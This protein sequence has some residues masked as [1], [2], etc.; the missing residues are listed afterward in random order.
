MRQESAGEADL[1]LGQGTWR[2]IEFQATVALAAMLTPL[3]STMLAVGLPSIRS[4]FDVGVGEMTLLISVYLVAVAAMQPVSGRL[5]DAYGSIRMMMVGLV[6]L[7]AISAVSALATN[8]PMLILMRGLQGAATALVL[9]NGIAV[10]RK[11]TP[12]ARL[13][14]VLGMNGAALSIA[15]ATGP[16]IG[17]A[18]LLAGDWR[19][20]FLVN[21]PLSV[22]AI[23]FLLRLKPD[24][25]HGRETLH[26]DTP[27]LLALVAV[28]GSAV[29][30]GSATR[31]ENPAFLVAGGA[32]LPVTVAA[33]WLRSRWGGSIVEFRFFRAGNFRA[34]ASSQGLT[35][36]VM[37]SF[38]VSLPLYLVDLRGVSDQVVSMVLF[39]LMAAMITL[40][41]V[42]GALTDRVG[43]RPLLL[44]GGFI[45]GVATVA[46]MLLFD[47]P[48]L[49]AIIGPLIGVGI[50]LGISGP[51]RSSAALEAWPRDV[52]GSV[53][54]T[55]SMMR[56]AGAI[57]GAAIIAALLGPDPGEGAFRLLTIVLA[58]VAILNIFVSLEIRDRPR[59]A[60]D[61]Q[62]EAGAPALERP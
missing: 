9:P 52:A 40:S 18:L 31:V 28:F 1:P 11:R 32:L 47:D 29:L 12:S 13:G 26:I 41:P 34:A 46:L 8:L 51:A 35:N 38:L 33:Y 43:R 10:L 53:S 27:S 5:G 54:G 42:G 44:G 55:F 60:T 61:A 3:N 14:T 20:L 4:H 7:I 6:L 24:E 21:V 45:I 19:L 36:L 59:A 50:G 56:Y 30:I 57:L 17:G 62:P 2:S 16:V 39:S 23:A 58:G 25:G 15:A 37:Y 49:A 22:V 48:P